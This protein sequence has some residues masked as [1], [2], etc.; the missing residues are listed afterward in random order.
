MPAL[1]LVPV[2]E[3][4]KEMHV[5]T[6]G[7]FVN[8]LGGKM[9]LVTSGVFD[10]WTPSVDRY[11]NMANA[12]EPPDAAFAQN[13]PHV[14]IRV[15]LDADYY[16]AE[17]P[18]TNKSYRQFVRETGHRAPSGEYLSFFWTTHS[19]A[20]W[21]LPGFD[22]DDLPVVG[23]DDEDMAAFCKWLSEKE[24]RTYRLPTVYEF[25]YAC[26]AGTDSLFWWGSHP[27]VRRMNYGVSMIG[28]PTPVGSYSPNPWGFYDMHGNVWE[29]CRDGGEFLAKGSAFNSPQLMTG[30]D[31]FGSFRFAEA[32]LLTV[33][34]R[35][36]CDAGENE[37]RVDDGLTPTILPARPEGPDYPDLEIIV[38]ERMDLGPLS[39]NCAN[40]MV[41]RDGT[42][43]LDNRRSTDQGKTWQSCTRIGEEDAYRQ[44]RDG[45]IMVVRGEVTFAD[46]VQGKGTIEVMTSTDDWQTVE[47]STA[48]IHVPLGLRF[49]PVRGLTE[50]DDGRLMMTMYGNFESDRVWT[51]SPV[52]VELINRYTWFKNRVILVE[53]SDRGRSWQYVSTVSYHPELTPMGTNESD[54][55]LLPD[56]QLIAAMRTGIHG[57]A[58]R[59][60]RR[61]LDQ[62]LLVAW[63]ND[64]GRT[65]TD[66]QQICVEDKLITGIYPRLL[67]T[68]DGVLAVLRC[69][70]DGSV[71][72]SPD[73]KGRMWTEEV[74]HYTGVARQGTPYH[75]GMQ[76]MALIAPNTLLVIDVVSKSGFPPT[77]GW[78]A[79]GIPITVEIQG[80]GT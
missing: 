15:E 46:P 66:P 21:E 44:L 62:P 60:G 70:P 45:T 42:W 16:L 1:G 5:R 11:V 7:S 28:E 68:G 6:T 59:H 47:S 29:T 27:D 36:A 67:M 51:A 30:A 53:S 38:G 17:F 35:L 25:E 18:V 37:E 80:D 24:G 77:G 3:E 33:G 8:S 58:D 69:R 23:L 74:V 14:P 78:H 40:F 76:D 65:W 56:G 49:I 73:G 75:A 72:F 4:A 48:S 41:T 13:R 79:E 55:L 22:A 57:Y 10:A 61:H 54:V 39:T 32:R 64:E 9:I 71:V 20:T 50:L 34:F 52:A 63:S 26:R 12:G 43:I 19:G 2:I 31:A